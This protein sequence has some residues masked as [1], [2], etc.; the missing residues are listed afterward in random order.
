MGFAYD[1]DKSCGFMAS[2]MEGLAN[3]ERGKNATFIHFYELA[4]ALKGCLQQEAW[5]NSKHAED[6]WLAARGIA[7]PGPRS[8]G[9][10]AQN[11]ERI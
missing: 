2:S 7:L 8:V 10:Y 11:L 1:T 6:E 5:V 4:C 9:P 3:L